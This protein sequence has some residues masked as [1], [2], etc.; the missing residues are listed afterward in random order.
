MGLQVVTF[1]IG[2]WTAQCF[3]NIVVRCRSCRSGREL[4]MTQLRGRECDLDQ[5]D[6]CAHKPL[7]SEALVLRAMDVLKTAPRRMQHAEPFICKFFIDSAKVYPRH[8]GDATKIRPGKQWTFV[9]YCNKPVP[10]PPFKICGICVLPLACTFCAVS[11]HDVQFLSYQLY[12]PKLRR[13]SC[14]RAILVVCPLRFPAQGL[15]PGPI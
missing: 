1:K 7:R 10:D 2:F 4:G 12:E 9:S 15:C 11:S 13:H 5:T 14:Q 3:A 8:Q 6:L